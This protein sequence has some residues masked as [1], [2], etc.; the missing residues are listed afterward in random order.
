MNDS[1]E[2]YWLR[3]IAQD[4]LKRKGESISEELSGSLARKLFPKEEETDVYCACLSED[5]DSLGQW[6]AYADD[7][8]GVPIGFSRH[9]LRQTEQEHHGVRLQSVV[10]NPTKQEQ[11]VE[12]IIDAK[13]GSACPSSA[14]SL[15]KEYTDDLPAVV[16]KVELW[17]EAARCKNPCFREEHEVRLVY[18]PSVE[19]PSPTLGERRFRSRGGAL[20]PYYALPIPTTVDDPQIPVRYRI[21]L[22]PKN[23]Q[24]QNKPAVMQL[25]SDEGYDVAQIK[26]STS[27]ATYGSSR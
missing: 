24:K 6:R 13:G 1:A 20:I 5:G 23:A 10:Y 4:V 21:V 11:I 18:E 16:A 3:G 8:R 27:A 17:F 7:G 26:V 15:P 2:H 25:F 19:S 22:G 14:S 12:D 9:L